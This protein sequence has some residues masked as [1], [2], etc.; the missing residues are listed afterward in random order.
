MRSSNVFLG[1]LWQRLTAALDLQELGSFADE[2]VGWRKSARGELLGAQQRGDTKLKAQHK[3]WRRGVEETLNTEAVCAG[4]LRAATVA[5]SRAS[6]AERGIQ[7]CLGGICD[8]ARW[9]VAHAPFIAQ[10]DAIGFRIPTDIWH[11]AAGVHYQ[12]LHAAIHTNRLR[13]QEDWHS[14]IVATA[15][16]VAVYDLARQPHFAGKQVANDFGL[17]PSLGMP[18]QVGKQLYGSSSHMNSYKTIPSGSR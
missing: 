11:I 17:G 10:E 14:R 9:P 4:V 1:Q 5:L 6:S 8:S 16:P 2:S 13:P 12:S 18:V 3:K 7:L 15:K